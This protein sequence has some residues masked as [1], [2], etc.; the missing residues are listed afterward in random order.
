MT[1]A[2]QARKRALDVVE[3]MAPNPPVGGLQPELR[4][5]DDLGFDS[6]RLV[7][8]TM[9]LEDAL[10]LVE[11]PSA[12]LGALAA[13][14]LATYTAVLL[15]NTATPTWAESRHHLPF[16]FAGSASAAASGNAMVWTPVAHAGPARALA[17]IGSS[18][19]LVALNRLEKHLDA[20][21][22]GEPL[23]HGTAGRLN[24]ASLALNVAGFVGTALFARRSRVASVL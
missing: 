17:L 19:D 4:L 18:V 22:V 2:A 21:G 14:P 5:I 23:H 7:E 3:A 20:H 13:G 15:S 8:L 10:E 9:A 11:A 24:K 1:D 6:L 16:V 12:A